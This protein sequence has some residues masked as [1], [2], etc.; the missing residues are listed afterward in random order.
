MRQNPF[1]EFDR[2]APPAC[3]GEPHAD[4]SD[5]NP[6]SAVRVNGLL[7]ATRNPFAEFV[8]KHAQKARHAHG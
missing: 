1:R 7:S 2:I 5:L 6:E 8:E 3:A 4:R